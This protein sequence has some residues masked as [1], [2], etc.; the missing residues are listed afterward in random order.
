M[1]CASD[2][3]AALGTFA[4]FVAAVAVALLAALVMSISMKV[5]E[6]DH[7]ARLRNIHI[8]IL[9]LGLLAGECLRNLRYLL[10]LKGVWE[11]HLEHY[12]QV[13]EFEGLLVVGHTVT[14][15]CLDFV[16]LDNFTWLVLDANLL[17]IK[18]SQHKVNTSKRLEESDLFL[19]HEICTAT[20]EGVVGLLL[21]LDH[22]ITSF[23]I[24]E[25]VGL[26]M[27][28]VLLTVGCTLVNLDLKN[29]LLLGNL[30]AEAFLALVLLVDYLALALA[31]VTRT[32]AL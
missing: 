12:E 1:L 8:D 5:F 10:R 21:D 28:H 4:F 11:G 32:G 2:S 22:Y 6:F 18:V 24:G 30:F 13:A 23:D 20:L 7:A 15:D 16:R 31:L 26:T 25:L 9:V 14:F 3:L 27:E 29:L 19:E 17:A